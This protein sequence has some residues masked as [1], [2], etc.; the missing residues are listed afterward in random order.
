M[1]R[2]D[3]FC[4][5]IDN[6]G[7]A[8][9]C[10][11]LAKQLSQ[12]YDL[13]VRLWIDNLNTLAHL[14]PEISTNQ[15]TQSIQPN[16]MVCH[17][18][19]SFDNACIAEV[20]IEAFGC[21]LPESYVS[22]M[23]R[24]LPKPIWINLEYLSMENWVAKCHGL[25]SIHPSLGLNKY[26]FFPGLTAGGLLREASLK[27][28]QDVWMRNSQI[29]S[30]TDIKVSLFSYHNPALL[31]LLEAWSQSQQNIYCRV[32]I[33]LA[34]E[35]ACVFFKKKTLQVGESIQ[36]GSLRLEVVPFLT[37]DEYDQ[38]LWQADL[39]FVRGEDSFV[40]GQLA[41]K[42]IIWQAYPQQDNVH[43]L[44]LNAFLDLYSNHLSDQAK[45]ALTQFHLAWNAKQN[46]ITE[47][48]MFYRHFDEFKKHAQHWCN[49]L[50]QQADLA[51]QLYDF[52]QA[53]I[54]DD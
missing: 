2:W 11:R 53:K 28:R 8:G 51:K 43:L 48:Q 38:L 4:R 1:K 10:W 50:Y 39:N 30:N 15:A 31:S 16:L 32:P 12:E 14:A 22:L 36:K 42:P 49:N 3:I 37:Q 44:K 9:V 40:R 27:K 54:S 18:T 41:S 13:T 47:W 6:Y 34:V 52:A 17:W 35:Q 19:D 5:V 46:C 23:A 21:T 33:G 20:V 45:I 25:A 7:D 29:S 26:F 24:H